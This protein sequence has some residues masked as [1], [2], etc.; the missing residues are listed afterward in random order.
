MHY[1]R[2]TDALLVD[3]ERLLNEGM[4]LTEVAAALGRPQS[5]DLIS[6]YLRARGVATNRRVYRPS[7]QAKEYPREMMVRLYVEGHSVKA[8]SER[9]GI[10]RATIR[11]Q[12]VREGI[13][14]RNRSESMFTRWS[15]ATEEDRRK[16]GEMMRRLVTG[17]QRSEAD[18]I[19]HAAGR[20]Q[21]VGEGEKILAEALRA[22]GI[23]FEPQ[24]PVHIYNIDLLVGPIA[25]ETRCR[26]DNP[27]RNPKRRA[28]TEY[29]LER[30][31]ATLW[32]THYNVE[33]LRACLNH[34]IA[35]IEEMGR[36]PSARRQHRVVRCQAH[37]FAASEKRDHP[38]DVPPPV[39]FRYYRIE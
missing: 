20:S 12:L 10:D 32:V 34:V 26:A 17:K 35:D 21:M 30:G 1:D 8:L 22:R 18:K 7:P 2:I 9:F 31:I 14:P 36:D 16:H 24:A 37:G 13:Q 5:R 3:A 27:M 19:R 4:T 28:R 15:G 6:E 38:S 39:R 11:A 25:V 23:E 33:A 29:L